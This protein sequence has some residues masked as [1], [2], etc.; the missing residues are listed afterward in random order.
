[1]CFI[2]QYVYGIKHIFYC[3]EYFSENRIVKI[4]DTL[5]KK[6]FLQNL[7]KLTNVNEKKIEKC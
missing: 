5:M 1:M 7:L 3:I 4:I 6:F 2:Q